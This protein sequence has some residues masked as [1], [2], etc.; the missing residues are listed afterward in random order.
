[1]DKEAA[2]CLEV[3]GHTEVEVVVEANH[4]Q[5]AEADSQA[6]AMTSDADVGLD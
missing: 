1:M 6:A 4:N 5:A 3:F 2:G